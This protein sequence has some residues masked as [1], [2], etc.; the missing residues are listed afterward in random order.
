[1]V[2]SLFLCYKCENV[3][4]GTNSQKIASDGFFFFETLLILF[5]FL[6]NFCFYFYFILLYNSVL[7]LP[8]DGFYVL[9][10]ELV[11]EEQQ[12]KEQRPPS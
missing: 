4:L 5:I 6:I 2:N 7:V 11:S 1:M 10:E 12:S 3:L 8:Y 9:R